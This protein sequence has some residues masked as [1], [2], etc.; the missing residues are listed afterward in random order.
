M[1][2]DSDE[3]ARHESLEAFKAWA[4]NN[5]NIASITYTGDSVKTYEDMTVTRE[6]QIVSGS[7]WREHPNGQEA[8]VT[9]VTR[10][11]KDFDEVLLST[12][13]LFKEAV[14]ATKD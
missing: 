2:W 11:H 12:D 3:S 8:T 1:T 5:P 14:K 7:D 10:H 4:A 13:P 6:T 9:T